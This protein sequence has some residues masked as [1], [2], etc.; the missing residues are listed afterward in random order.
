[1]SD[2]IVEIRGGVLI[3]IYGNDSNVR[4]IVIDWD[5]LQDGEVGGNAGFKWGP[6]QPLSSLPAD[7]RE[8]YQRAI[9]AN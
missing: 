5:K 6:C 4:V 9:E 2:V 8:Q 1:M 3:E 7:T